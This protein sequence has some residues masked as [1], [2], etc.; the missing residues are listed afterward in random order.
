MAGMGGILCNR[1]DA[2]NMSFSSH[3][4]L[5]SSN[6][7]E[8]MALRGCKAKYLFKH[9]IVEGDSLCVIH[10]ASGLY[11]PPWCLAN[12]VEEVVDLAQHIQ[13]SS[14]HAK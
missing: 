5:C 14:I 1:T 2:N 9:I 11:M 6:E 13:A 3:A 12:V 8:I 7:A 4:I 10:W